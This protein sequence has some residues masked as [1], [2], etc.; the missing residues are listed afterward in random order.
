VT[1]SSPSPYTW[2]T[3]RAEKLVRDWGMNTLPI[4]VESIARN[5]AIEVQAMPASIKGVSGMLQRAGDN[6]GIAY[7]TNID[8]VGFQ[9]FSIAHELGHYFLDGHFEKLLSKTGTHESQAGFGSGDKFEME[10]DHFAAGLL[11]PNPL[12]K[13]ALVRAGSGFTA[14]ERLSTQF[15][16]SL[17]ATAIRYAENTDQAAAVIVSEGQKVRYCFMSNA[18]REARDL[19][20]IRKGEIVPEHTTTAVF[21]RD[22]EKIERAE[23]VEGTCNLHDWFGGGPDVEMTED[24]VGLGR[25]GKTLTVLVADE[26]PDDENEDDED[27]SDFNPTFHRS[28]RR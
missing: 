10:A 22:S 11:M 27:L 17:E 2:A 7:A 20:W 18:L 28:R 14:V 1:P 6:Y 26:W 23:K 3:H 13:D 5:H 25:Y 16:T 19:T 12:F 8:N 24:V 21:N 15:A 9:R 4:D